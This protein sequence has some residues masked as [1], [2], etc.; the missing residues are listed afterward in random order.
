LRRERR[1]SAAVLLLVCC[2][3]L[4]TPAFA[5]E[6]PSAAP[7]QPGAPAEPTAGGP[8]AQT[9]P[10]DIEELRRRLDVLAA[11]VERLRSGEPEAV[12][13]TAER[14]RALGLAP[15]AARTYQRSSQG[16]SFAGYGEMLAENYASENE[17][18]AGGAPTTRFDFLRAV[19]YTGYRFNDRFLFNSELEVEHGNEIFVEFAYVDFLAHQ[20][21]T[22]RGGLVL[23]PLG[24]VNEFHEPNV[25]FGARRPETEQR[26]IPSTWRENGGG[27]LGSAGPVNFRAYVTNGFAGT[28]FR[29]NG[30]R[31]GRQRGIQA[32]AANLA[33]S[34]RIDVTP[35]PGVFGGV[36]VYTGGSGQEQVSF[37][38]QPLDMDTTVA[39]VHGQAQIRGFDVRA[40][41]ARATVDDAGDAS[42]AIGPTLLGLNTAIAEEM[43]GGYVQ[44]AYNLLSQVTSGLA[45]SPYVR[46]EKVDTQHRV[47]DGFTR[48][49]AQDGTF[50]TFGVDVK[51]I[52]NVVLKGEYQWV[53]NEAGSGRSQFN[54]NLGYS[55]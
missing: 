29:A 49:L 5:Q 6:G 25:F 41:F 23:I 18:G 24:L 17:S 36:G 9:R 28:N 21:L 33:F 44:V 31:G 32:R 43:Q 19:L 38:G 26:I 15:S 50:K 16:I 13:L 11:E 1:T 42:R 48:A 14:R 34:G 46:F 20:N 2:V 47:P 55:F 10:E 45:V 35:I 51:P 12:E 3:S 4:N 53:T 8:A 52:P 30:L 27:I 54:L 7:A 22:L 37:A 39:E 40:L